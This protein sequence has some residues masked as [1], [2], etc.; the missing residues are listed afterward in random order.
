MSKGFDCEGIEELIKNFSDIQKLFPK[1]ADKLLKKAGNKAA[2]RM[3][4]AYRKKTK[5][6][7]GNLL[8]GVKRGKPYTYAKDERQVRV[9]N[10]AKHAHLIEYGH[11]QT[12]HLPDK[13][14][15]GEF[16]K[17][18]YIVKEEQNAINQEFYEALDGFLD[19][20][21]EVTIK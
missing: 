18:R 1:E 20:F 5:K 8:K 21:L 13:K 9:S 19:D 6:R 10:K 14:D 4:K 12:G 15:T 16:I 7:T 3:R 17:G 11:N 2:N